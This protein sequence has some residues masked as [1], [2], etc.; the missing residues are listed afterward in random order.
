MAK[1]KLTEDQMREINLSNAIS[2]IGTCDET[3]LPQLMLA[4]KFRLD[5]FNKLH[6]KPSDK[7]IKLGLN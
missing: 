4:I 1:A 7:I 3:E 6:S 5:Y 2:V